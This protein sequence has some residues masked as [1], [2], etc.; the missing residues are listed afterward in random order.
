VHLD[1]GF[2]KIHVIASARAFWPDAAGANGDPIEQMVLQV[3]YPDS[4]GAIVYKNSG[5]F[6]DN[7]GAAKSTT[8]APAIWTKDN[9]SRIIIF[10]FERQNALPPDQQNIIYIKRQ[11]RF[12]QQPCVEIP[13]RTL[14]PPEEKTSEHSIEVRADALGMLRIGPI[15]LDTRLDDRTKAM[16]MFRKAHRDPETLRFALDNVS[17][18]QFF[19]AWTVDPADAL[20][21]SYQV[22]MIIE[23]KVAGVPAITY[24][25]P[26]IAMAGSTPL[27]AMVPMPPDDL[28]DQIA[29]LRQ[30]GALLGDDF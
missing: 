7:V 15:Q 27:V 12:Q 6:M 4:H 19:E 26:E 24:T 5:L 8:L 30:V 2:R 9:K 14:T 17:Q 21:W 25:G 1:E 11:I 16:I 10:D 23:S 3:G 22:T 13:G 29:K 28:K 18:P 20:Y